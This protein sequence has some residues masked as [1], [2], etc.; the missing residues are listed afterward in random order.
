M[1]RSR[2]LP[3]LFRITTTTRKSSTLSYGSH[4]FRFLSSSHLGSSS[5]SNSNSS[6]IG[7]SYVS[8]GRWFSNSSSSNGGGGGVGLGKKYED[9]TIGIPKE[10]VSLERRVAATPEVRRCH[11]CHDSFF[12]FYLLGIGV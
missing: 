12:I 9:L 1:H 5:S 11:V 7:S 2:K 6:V 4:R 8:S 3:F 10:I